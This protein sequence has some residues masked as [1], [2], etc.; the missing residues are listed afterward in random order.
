MTR[1]VRILALVAVLAL[2][3]A[4]PVAADHCGSDATVSPTSG[5]PGTTFVFRS[6]LGAP[7]ELRVY[8]N[9]VLVRQVELPGQG[10]ERYRIRT[11]PGD[12]GSWRARAEVVG[13]PDCAAEATFTV[14]GA[15]DTSTD[16]RGDQSPPIGTAV[17]I[18]AG[19]ATT[20]GVLLR[21]RSSRG[22]VE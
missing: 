19:L 5:P 15:P 17:A 9:D 8:R 12:A 16:L 10:F 21:L 22:R 18:G 13:R 11:G 6:Y 1:L 7:S 2:G 14:I 3:L 4:E 20:L